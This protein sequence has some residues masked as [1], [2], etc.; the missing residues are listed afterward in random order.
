MTQTEIQVVCGIQTNL[1]DGHMDMEAQVAFVT[2]HAGAK[3]LHALFAILVQE[4]EDQIGHPIDFDPG[5][6]DDLRKMINANRAATG[7]QPLSES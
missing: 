2:T 7:R 3:S 5:K 4:H 1:G 6:L